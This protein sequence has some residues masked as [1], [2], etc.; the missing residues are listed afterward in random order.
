MVLAWLIARETGLQIGEALKLSWLNIKLRTAMAKRVV[1]FKYKKINGEIREARGT[2][3]EY[4]IPTRSDGSG[5]RKPN[6]HVQCYYD[7]DKTAW[8]SFRKSHLI[9]LK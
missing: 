9:E 3:S 6:I 1:S 5:V 4:E 7:C 2:L 8:R